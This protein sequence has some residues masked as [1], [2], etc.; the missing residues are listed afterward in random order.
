MGSDVTGL[1]ELTEAMPSMEAK[2]MV[3]AAGSSTTNCLCC[4][5]GDKETKHAGRGKS[6]GSL[7]PHVLTDFASLL[8]APR[9]KIQDTEEDFRTAGVFSSKKFAKG[10]PHTALR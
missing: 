9:F 5:E 10:P 8:P 2:F 6:F 4:G 1:G 3:E 7:P